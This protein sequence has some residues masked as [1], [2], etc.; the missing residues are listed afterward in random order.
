MYE[1]IRLSGMYLDSFWWYRSY[2]QSNQASREMRIRERTNEDR[3][4]VKVRSKPWGLGISNV[5]MIFGDW[6]RARARN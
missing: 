1:L 3:S 5:G 2:Q 4:V 6:W